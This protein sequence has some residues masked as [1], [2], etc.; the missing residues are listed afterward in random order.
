M[1]KY[2]IILILAATLFP[3]GISYA[4]RDARCWTKSACVEYVKTNFGVPETQAKEGFYSAKDHSDAQAACKGIEDPTTKDELGFCPPVGK[5]K[6]RISFGGENEFANLGTFIQYIYRY[7]FII[8]SVIAVVMVM[9]AGVLWI[10]SGGSQE[11]IGKARKHISNA[12]IGLVLLALSY[13]ILNMVNPY[14]TNLRLPDVWIVNTQQTLTAYCNDLSENT[15]INIVGN[16]GDEIT[17]AQIDIAQQ[18]AFVLG[19]KKAECGK[20]YIAEDGGGQTCQGNLCGFNQACVPFG[21][22]NGKKTD[23]PTCMKG[24]VITHLAI[25][26]PFTKLIQA[27]AGAGIVV[28]QIEDEYLDTGA[29]GDPNVVAICD[30]GSKKYLGDNESWDDQNNWGCNKETW[31]LTEIN[32]TPKEYLLQINNIIGNTCAAWKPNQWGCG[33]DDILGFTIQH[34]LKLNWDKDDPYVYI[35]KN[36]VGK[37]NQ[38]VGIDNLL[39]WDDEKIP[40]CN[41]GKCTK[42]IYVEGSIGQFNFLPVATCPKQD[43]DECCNDTDKPGDIVTPMSFCSDNEGN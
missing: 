29:D 41:D 14:L 21:I 35:G 12:I 4:Q 16:A 32:T 18:K 11:L 38:H 9:L 39:N 23:T 17:D 31:K 27:A 40:D 24:D 22:S 3:A 15:K 8:G 42:G 30:N 7:G 13:T 5:A 6:T 36:G 28:K 26:D 37:W 34:E 10:F 19:A 33:S 20:Q 43:P 2:V 25:T 1:K